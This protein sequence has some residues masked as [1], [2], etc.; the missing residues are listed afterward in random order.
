M[1]LCSLLLGFSLDAWVVVGTRFDAAG[2]ESD[3]AW[4]MT[5]AGAPVSL[6]TPYLA[7]YNRGPDVGATSVVFWDTLTGGRGAPDTVSPS[8]MR[9]RS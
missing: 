2:N 9:S 4:V 7:A 8:G 1:L 3:H 6:R 5:R